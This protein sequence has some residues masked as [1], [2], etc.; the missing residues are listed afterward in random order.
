MALTCNLSLLHL[1]NWAGRE[2][3]AD[4]EAAAHSQCQ[5]EDRPMGLLKIAAG[6]AGV[7]WL[8]SPTKTLGPASIPPCTVQLAHF[9]WYSFLQIL[10][11]LLFFQQNRS[12]AVLTEKYH[13]KLWEQMWLLPVVRG[14]S[15]EEKK[16]SGP[17]PW[18]LL[19]IFFTKYWESGEGF[20]F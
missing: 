4:G 10:S 20:L 15:T 8:V 3:C 14:K 13:P 16:N 2:S 5:R 12:V 11:L 19:E 7:C 6:L 17:I 1:G 9:N 18:C